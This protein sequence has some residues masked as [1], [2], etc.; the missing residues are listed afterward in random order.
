MGVVSC[1][2]WVAGYPFFAALFFSFWM[3]SDMTDGTIARGCDLG[4]DTGKWLDP[5]SD[6]FMYIPLLLLL[7]QLTPTHAPEHYETLSLV[8]VLLFIV[9]DILSQLSRLFVAKTAANSFGKAKTMMIC[10]TLVVVSFRFISF[11]AFISLPVIGH[12]NPNYLMW[13]AVALGFLSFYCK[14]IPDHW[15]A[16]SL[17]L[18]NF[19]CGLAAIPLV[20]SNHN[21]IGAFILIF[22]GQFFDL[23]DGRTARKFGSTEWGALFDDIAD[24]TSFGLAIAVIVYVTILPL[25]IPFAIFSSLLYFICVVYR[26]YYFLINKGEGTPGIFVGMPSPAGAMLAGSSALLFNEGGAI[27]IT[28]LTT[29]IASW[30]MVSKIEYKHFGQKILSNVP[31]GVKL[32]GFAV[33]LSYITILIREQDQLSDAFAIFSFSLIWLYIFIGVNFKNKGD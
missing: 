33:V 23:L 5:L 18:M 24:G 12:I 30:L 13:S 20:L 25:G 7:T 27:W 10:I 1:L 15:Y 21:F 9:F 11:D 29:I 4:T 6:K 16:N 31:N 8:A 22:L 2:I 14:V 3:I 17:T 26:L 19:I 28:F 32:A